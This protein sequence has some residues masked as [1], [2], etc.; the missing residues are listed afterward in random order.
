MFLNEH[1]RELVFAQRTFVITTS[2]RSTFYSGPYRIG[3]THKD[4]NKTFYLKTRKIQMLSHRDSS[5]N[6]EYVFESALVCK[7]NQ[8]NHCGSRDV[9]LL[10]AHLLSPRGGQTDVVI[11][12]KHL[13]ETIYVTSSHDSHKAARGR[14]IGSSPMNCR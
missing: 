7:R 12:S 1:V 3:E 9:S 10:F 4:T 8:Y 5:C 11:G 14:E 13:L 2:T 6:R